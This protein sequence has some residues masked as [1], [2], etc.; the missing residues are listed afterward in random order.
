MLFRQFTSA[1]L[2]CVLFLSTKATARADDCSITSPVPPPVPSVAAVFKPGVS[3]NING[4]A[5]GA[6]FR[7]FKVDWARGVSPAGGWTNTGITLAGGGGTPVTSGPLAVWASG[8]V[9]QADYYSVRLSVDN[10]TVTNVASTLVYLEPDLYSTN[11]PLW[12]DQ[13]P[14]ENSALPV[15]DAGGHTRLALVNPVYSSTVVPSR[16]WLF[17][18]DGSSY[19][20]FPLD[21]ASYMQPAAANLD[22]QA[23]DELVVAEWS[24]LRVFRADNS[25]Y[26]LTPPRFSNF[27]M[28]LMTVADLN[29]DTWP[30]IVALGSDLGSTNAYLYAWTTNGQLFSTNY[31]VQIPDANFDLRSMEWNRVVPADL[32]ND[33]KPELLVVAGDT[34]SSF[35]LRL[36]RGDGKPADWSVPVISGTFRYL[37]VGDLDHDGSPEIV[38]AYSDAASLNWVQVYSAKGVPR[39]GWP[40]QLG[41]GT[42][43][44]LLLADL[45]RDGGNE[46][47]AT[48]Y[49][50]LY[51]FRADGSAYPGWPHYGGTYEV[52]S[53]PIVADVTGDGSPEIIVAHDNLFW[54]GTYYTETTLAAYR[55]NGSIARS[56]RLLG[57]DGNQPSGEGTPTYG[58]FD[59]DGLAELALNYRVISG[60]GI[61]GYLHEGVMTVL[62]LGI[63]YR[64]DHRDWPVSF[65]DLRNTAVGF[66]AA[67]LNVAKSGANMR[68]SWPVQP[69]S[70]FPQFSDQLNPASW[71]PLTGL[72]TLDNGF[73]SATVPIT[74]AHQWYRLRYP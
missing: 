52:L 5:A 38:M 29:A 12:L 60:G 1:V 46:I 25:S 67:K 54:A 65:H 3:L 10:T 30:E 32:D 58:D 14:G 62:R 16:L 50:D 26:V 11:W 49:A 35:S 63:P 61:S 7:G 47:I 19:T 23:G 57:A 42:P 41:G 39:P 51:V 9:T 68:L 37:A 66:T 22:H 40:V 69:D 6:G 56:W 2:V 4:N 36:L 21:H 71:R 72:V 48:E 13:A 18:V 53:V 33:G 74:N 59:G 45:N 44:R 20:N 8:V 31:P 64:A 70:P 73:Y 34:P 55:T 15:R 17:G 27:Q 28:A 43:V 24:S